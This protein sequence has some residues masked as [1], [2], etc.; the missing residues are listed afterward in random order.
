MEKDDSFETQRSQNRR[1]K[2]RGNE[3]FNIVCRRYPVCI[4]KTIY[5]YFERFN[6][7]SVRLRLKFINGDPKIPIGDQCK[8]GRARENG[9]RK[10][11]Q[12]LHKKLP[13]NKIIR[14][15]KKNDRKI[16]R[17]KFEYEHFKLI[18]NSWL[19][20]LTMLTTN[21]SI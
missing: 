9:P 6:S 1:R 20:K 14:K 10:T 12:N 11:G 7:W 17:N 21:H 8:S 2:S 15:L 5:R 19:L 3:D 16:Q 18:T 4:A 13:T